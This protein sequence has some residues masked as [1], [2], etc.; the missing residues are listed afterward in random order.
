MGLAGGN[1]AGGPSERVGPGECANCSPLWIMILF[2]HTDA[3]EATRAP[4]GQ[5]SSSRTG[6][7]RIT[8]NAAVALRPTLMFARP[9]GAAGKQTSRPTRAAGEV[10]FAGDGMVSHGS[11]RRML[12]GGGT[13]FGL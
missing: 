12:G 13:P 9:L 10:S 3:H 7:N 8:S 1:Q 6:S 5:M 2:A 11:G 4:L